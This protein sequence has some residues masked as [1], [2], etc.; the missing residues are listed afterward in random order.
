[1]DARAVKLLD[2]D[3]LLEVSENKDEPGK[4]TIGL[5]QSA[6]VLGS[7]FA[8]SAQQ[9]IDLSE[10]LVGACIDGHHDLA[11]ELI[12]QGA[13][14]HYSSRRH[15][16]SVKMIGGYYDKQ[17]LSTPIEIAAARGLARLVK[18]LIEKG[19]NPNITYPSHPVGVAQYAF[20]RSEETLLHVAARSMPDNAAVIKALIDLAT[21]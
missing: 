14:I 12:D 9:K 17:W 7:M 8:L 11:L 5:K 3:S 18:I 10:R 21:I 6:L 15:Q 16:I 1:M 20:M 2:D 13:D 19:V 4:F